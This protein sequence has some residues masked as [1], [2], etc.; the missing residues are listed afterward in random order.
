MQ[1]NATKNHV[2]KELFA[3][4]AGL[5]E[6]QLVHVAILLPVSQWQ[7]TG[8]CEKEQKNYKSHLVNV[9]LRC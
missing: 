7:R 9:F 4:A 6:I 3:V 8:C 2:D 5:H 1:I